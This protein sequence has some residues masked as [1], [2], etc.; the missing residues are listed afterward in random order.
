MKA[1]LGAPDDA[2]SEGDTFSFWYKHLRIYN[3]DTGKEQS[4]LWVSTRNSNGN[5]GA[6]TVE[7]Y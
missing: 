1:I 5:G 2:T 4:V 3:P 6:G 7:A